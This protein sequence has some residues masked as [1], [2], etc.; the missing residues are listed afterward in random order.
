MRPGVIFLIVILIIPWVIVMFYIIAKKRS[1]GKYFKKLQD[2]YTLETD[3]ADKKHYEISGQYRSRPIKIETGAPDVK[4]KPGTMLKVMCENPS[5]FT[6]TLVK[7]SKSSNPYYSEGAYMVE[8]KEFDD[9][10]IIQTNNVEKMQRLF[11]F[12]TRFKL[13]QVNG[14]G[15]DGEISLLGNEFMY[16]EPGVMTNDIE[17]MKL[18]LVLHELCDLADVLKYN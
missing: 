10:F 14:L 2:K 12:N 16:Y 7:R 9:K 3:S 8:D 13:I 18:E 6:F 17:M 4:K 1:A 11:D 5:D 15:F